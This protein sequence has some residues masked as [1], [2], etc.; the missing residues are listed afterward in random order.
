MVPHVHLPTA[1]N[2]FRGVI[3]STVTYVLNP[4]IKNQKAVVSIDSETH[5]SQIA[6]V[7][8]PSHPHIATATCHGL[9]NPAITIVNLAVVNRKELVSPFLPPTDILT[10]TSVL[11]PIFDHVALECLEENT[12][13]VS[14]ITNEILPIFDH[15]VLESYIVDR[16]SWWYKS[17][18]K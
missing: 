13:A 5:K 3:N 2:T 16:L 14:N 9:I 18:R 1:T 7:V 17:H 8:A 10:I 6:G 12:T 4:A 11:P 15:V